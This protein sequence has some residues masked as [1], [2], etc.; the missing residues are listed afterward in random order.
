MLSN[1]PVAFR[2]TR[3]SFDRASRVSGMR[4]PDR[5]ILALF[6]STIGF[7]QPQWSPEARESLTMCRQVGDTSYCITL[8]FD[9]WAQHL[10]NEGFEASELHN[11]QLVLH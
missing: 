1:A 10:A 3:M 11:E 2:C 7:R 5:A 8:D 9:V 6:S 4:A